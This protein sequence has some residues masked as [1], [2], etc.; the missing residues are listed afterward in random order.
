MPVDPLDKT[1]SIR[2]GG[3]CGYWG[4]SPMATPQFLGAQAVD[5]IVYDYLA[6][7]TMSLMARARAKDANAGFATDFIS[8]VLQPNLHAIADQGV[9]LLTN[10][11][12][13]NP[14]ACARAVR[15][16]ISA[17][18]LDLTVGVITG[19][20]LLAHRD[21]LAALAPKDVSDGR[22]FPD[23]E[24]I[25]S[26]NAYI[27]A[28]PLAM[29]LDQG[30]DIVIA[31]RCVDS[32]LTLGACIHHFGW[33]ATEWDK[34]AA[35]SLAGHLIECG[36]QATGGNFTDW[37]ESGDI[38]AI[39]YP[40][41]TITDDGACTLTK[42]AATTGLVSVGTVS[43]Q[44]LY[45]IGDPAAYHLPDVTC[46]FTGVIITQAG[47]DQV[48]V[49]GARGMAPPHTLKTCL[50]HTNGYRTGMQIAHYG[51][52]AELKALAFS[53]AALDR[54]N[55]NLRAS[56]LGDFSEVSVEI[57]GANAQFG[58]ALQPALEVVSK[59]A[60][61]HPSPF[62]C[63]IL[64]KEIAGLG[65]AA[66]PGLSG[67]QGTRPKPSPV[68]QLFTFPLDRQHLTLTVQVGPDD[69]GPLQTTIPAYPAGADQAPVTPA[70]PNN[71][72]SKP[73]PLGDMV[74]M[75]LVNLA[76]GRSGDKGDSA[77]IGII[78]RRPDYLP[79]IWHELSVETVHRVFAHFLAADCPPANL[80]KFLLP[81]SHAINFLL[82]GVLGGGGTASLRSDPQGKGYA[83]I[84]LTT[85]IPIP[86][87]LVQA[88]S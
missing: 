26:I 64:L 80:G 41:A 34:L 84:L 56:N 83:Q 16:L 71:P 48:R 10:A 21:R 52:D 73:A 3:A 77:N 19:D 49:T 47:E 70:T 44:M 40:I 86:T 58:T 17:M 88:R 12:G 1:T 53:N 74:S 61:K 28:F 54:A 62:G 15:A 82:P 76:Y 55:A 35:G 27:G 33:Q 30:A 87:D 59:I 69:Q 9:R 45:E 22:P 8:G 5:F 60:V 25:T 57:L 66:A 81:G 11:G 4:E 75:P 2:I 51:I 7:I 65:L 29:A 6:E 39:G 24:T 63:A 38:A 67:F 20:D 37:G 36:P 72:P 46:D 79:W 68:Y 32:A 13:V 50:T 23:P 18:G 42:P 31:G 43:E 85:P 14:E 78:A